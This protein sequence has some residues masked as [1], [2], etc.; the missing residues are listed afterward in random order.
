[1]AFASAADLFSL[2]KEG[3]VLCRNLRGKNV[4]RYPH[5]TAATPPAHA[6]IRIP[7]LGKIRSWSCFLFSRYP[8]VSRKLGTANLFDFPRQGSSLRALK[9][10]EALQFGF[11]LMLF[12]STGF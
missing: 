4:A 3:E 7:E 2:G 11:H 10:D 12:C 1:M 5:L 9:V 6:M 8:L